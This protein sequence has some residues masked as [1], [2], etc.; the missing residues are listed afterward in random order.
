MNYQVAEEWEYELQEIEANQAS[1]SNS[2]EEIEKADSSQWELVKDVIP[3]APVKYHNNI[4]LSYEEVLT[5]PVYWVFHITNDSFPNGLYIVG[6]PRDG[7]TTYDYRGIAQ[8]LTAAHS[9][10]TQGNRYW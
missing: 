5:Y 9:I 6:S 4:I 3:E 8:N 2:N 10:G 1:Y 7:L